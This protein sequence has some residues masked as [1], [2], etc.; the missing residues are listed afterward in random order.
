MLHCYCKISIKFS[1][2]KILHRKSTKHSKFVPCFKVTGQ[3]ILNFQLLKI[4]LKISTD[5]R[6]V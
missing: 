5:L 3:N 4:V 6:Y 2:I 1:L